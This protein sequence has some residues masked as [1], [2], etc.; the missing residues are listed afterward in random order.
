MLDLSVR[1]ASE[2]LSAGLAGSPS[3]GSRSSSS[4]RPGRTCFVQGAR[5]SGPGRFGFHAWS[6][7]IRH[8]QA[9]SQNVTG[10]GEY[11]AVG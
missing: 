5:Y 8:I 2:R 4:L 1:Q 6:T 9:T 3:I 11:P 10:K 7:T